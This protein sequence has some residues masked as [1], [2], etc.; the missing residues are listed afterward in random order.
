MELTW[1]LCISMIIPGA[2]VYNIIRPLSVN[3]TKEGLDS[4]AFWILLL[5]VSTW[6]RDK[7]EMDKGRRIYSRKR[8]Q[9]CRCEKIPDVWRDDK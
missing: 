1:K 8:N 7:M 5:A 6:R 3:Y 9:R 2:A 4:S